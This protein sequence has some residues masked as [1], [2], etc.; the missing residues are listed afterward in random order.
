MTNF[1]LFV[2]FKLITG[3]GLST[4]TISKRKEEPLDANLTSF[5][6]KKHVVCFS[7]SID[8][9]KTSS[10]LQDRNRILQIKYKILPQSTITSY[11]DQ[12]AII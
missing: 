9:L 10:R 8:R 1:L 2:K 11:R 7:L 5:Q 12:L 4:T 6:V 3:F